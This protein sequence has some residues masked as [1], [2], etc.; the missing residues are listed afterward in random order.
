[1]AVIG[2][3]CE[4]AFAAIFKGKPTDIFAG[5]VRVEGTRAEVDLVQPGQSEPATSLVATRTG[6]EWRLIDE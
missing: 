1:M 5:D 3:S 4:K 6:G 2:G